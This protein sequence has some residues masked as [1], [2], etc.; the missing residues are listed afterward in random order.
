MIAK[1]LSAS[2]LQQSQHWADARLRPLSKQARSWRAPAWLGPTIIALTGSIMLT[3]SWGTWPDPIVDAGRELYVPW[4]LTCGDRLYTDIA[5]FNG[6]LSPYFNAG[7]FALFGVSL[8]TLLIANVAILALLTTLAYK[9]INELAGRGAAT[10]AGLVLVVVFALGQYS[11]E[12]DNNNHL[13]PYSHELTHG[14]T[15]GFASLC[16]LSKYLRTKRRGSAAGIGF[17][18]G[19]VFLTKPEIFLA[20]TLAMT[21][22]LWRRPKP[23]MLALI[24]AAVPIAIAFALLPTAGVLGAWP[25]TL[26]GEV[27]RLPFYRELM[28]VFDLR[29]SLIGLAI[30]TAVYAAFAVAVAACSR[31]QSSRLT[32]FAVLALVTAT[33]AWMAIE[34]PDAFRPLPIVSLVVAVR[35]FRRDVLRLAFS[36]FALA[37]MLKIIL[38]AR[39]FHYGQFLAMPAMLLL[40]AML[41]EWF[42]TWLH[43]R[44]GDIETAR[45]A[46]VAMVAG[47]VFV[48]LGISAGDISTKRHDVA[49]GADTF[50]ADSR[51][52]AVNLAL[53]KIEEH[54]TPEQ[55]LAVLPEGVM[56]NYLSRRA[57]PTP[58][59]NFMPPE[60]LMFGEDHMLDAFEAHPPHFVCMLHKYKSEIVFPGFGSEYATKL[61]DWVQ[62][63]YQPI[64]EPDNDL[65]LV[66]MRRKQ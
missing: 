66:L 31:V 37:L 2:A 63:H 39:T 40:V 7:L 42:P 12:I 23:A 34:F 59:I 25:A 19:L 62:H 22:G 50:K 1:T 8:R 32:N 20:T 61:N 33:G 18:M 36:V 13:L 24:V 29:A 46:G 4:R 43:R 51:A 52:S 14:L 10:A 60:M 55:T 48:H 9:L 44:G 6:P 28:G 64:K 38:Y 56:L 16:M 57:N 35:S 53:K 3:W 54:I 26:K 58:Y 5:Y 49:A 11:S 17:C 27:G 65:G 30:S 15:L 41:V 47:I 45:F 21:V